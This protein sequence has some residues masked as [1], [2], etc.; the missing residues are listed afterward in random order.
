MAAAKHRTPCK[1]SL[2]WIGDAV[3]PRVPCYCR[4]F[5]DLGHSEFAYTLIKKGVTISLD[6]GERE[7]E[8]VSRMISALYPK[9]LSMATIGACV[10]MG[11]ALLCPHTPSRHHGCDCDVVCMGEPPVRSRDRIQEAVCRQR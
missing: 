10:G 11:R 4:A 9:V 5:K 6:Y 1:G 2:T 3:C 8:L 7:K